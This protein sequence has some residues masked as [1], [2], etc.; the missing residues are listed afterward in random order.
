[1]VGMSATPVLLYSIG[2]EQFPTVDELCR[3]LTRLGVERVV[4][5]RELPRSRRRGF[6]RG[7]LESALA[8][9]GIAYEHRR[10]LGNPPEI[11]AAYR[12]GDR[13]RGREAYRARL[14]ERPWA[15]DGLAEAAA[16]RPTA[17]LCLED[18]QARCHRDVI[19]EEL[20]RRHPAIRVEPRSGLRGGSA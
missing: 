11:R 5:V 17:M 12:S 16:E 2:Y 9:A 6:S 19:A 14:L 7:A 1:M 3:V 18:E 20:A 15:L 4:D 10:E 8:G 13:A